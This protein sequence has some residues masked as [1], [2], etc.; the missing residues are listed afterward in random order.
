[1]EERPFACGEIGRGNGDGGLGSAR[2]L[3]FVAAAEIVTPR[4]VYMELAARTTHSPT[5]HL[6]TLQDV[7]ML[8]D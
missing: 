6:E 5:A 3:L 2:R 4:C 8:K 1:M 7:E